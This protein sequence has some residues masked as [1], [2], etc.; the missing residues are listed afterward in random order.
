[1]LLEQLVHSGIAPSRLMPGT[2]CCALSDSVRLSAHAVAC[3][4][5]GVLMLP[6]FY[7]KEVN[8]E[9]LYRSYSEVIERFGDRRLRLYLYHIPPDAHLGNPLGLTER[10]PKA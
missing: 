1:M 6:P 4:C 7:Y 8:E 10:L 2:G 3:G 9:G 5:A